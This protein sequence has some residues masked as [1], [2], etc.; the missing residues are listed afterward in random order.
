V[1]EYV[2]GQPLTARD[3]FGLC[4][5]REKLDNILKSMFS[6]CGASAITTS[7]GRASGQGSVPQYV[8]TTI[9]AAGVYTAYGEWTTGKEVNDARDAVERARQSGTR[10]GSRMGDRFAESGAALSTYNK[11]GE[12]RRI[13]ARR[14]RFGCCGNCD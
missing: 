8:S 4:A 6:Q 14:Q 7:S 9:T 1:Y 2:R 5:A 13:Q 11:D 10:M 12:K 3:P